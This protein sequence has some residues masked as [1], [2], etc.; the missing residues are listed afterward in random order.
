MTLEP[1]HPLH[2]PSHLPR[3]PARDRR[4]SAFKVAPQQAWRELLEEIA[5]FDGQAVI[6]STNA[7]R[8]RDGRIYTDALDEKLEDPGVAVFF[9]WAGRRVVFACDT[10]LT[11]WENLRALH[12]TIDALRRIERNGAHQLFDRAFTG[13][14]ALPAPDSTPWWTVLGVPQTATVAEINAAWRPGRAQSGT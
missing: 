3:T 13:F 2:W 8:R 4:A 11:I 12:G 1:Q 6:I 5:R 7:P 9:T 14:A 10:F